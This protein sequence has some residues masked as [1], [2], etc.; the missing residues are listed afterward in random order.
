MT[1]I[2]KADVVPNEALVLDCYTFA[3]KSMG[4]D[5]AP[6]AHDGVLLNFDKRSDPSAF[7]NRAAVKI[8][9]FRMHDFDVGG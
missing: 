9:Q 2:D 6:R 1:V 5:F 8:D 4:T 7:A 3:D